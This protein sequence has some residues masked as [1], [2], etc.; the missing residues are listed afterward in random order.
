MSSTAK[1]EIEG[2]DGKAGKGSADGTDPAL[3][4]KRWDLFQMGND[5]VAKVKGIEENSFE[6]PKWTSS[7]LGG[8]VQ[9]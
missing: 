7:H 1:T 6:K 9:G 2:R 8:T 3:L 4:P 5:R